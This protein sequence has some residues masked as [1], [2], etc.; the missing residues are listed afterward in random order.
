MCTCITVIEYKFCWL[1]LHVRSGLSPFNVSFVVLCLFFLQSFCKTARCMID[2]DS[3]PSSAFCAPDVPGLKVAAT[4]A[5]DLIPS[6]YNYI[7]L[8]EC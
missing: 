7:V 3:L 6:E 5:G 8:G 4:S 1:L 2:G